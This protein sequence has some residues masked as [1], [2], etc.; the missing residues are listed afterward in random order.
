MNFGEVIAHTRKQ[1]GVSQKD[2]AA[3]I[4]KEDG[5]SISAQYLNDIERDRRNPP[6]DYIVQQLAA[7]LELSYEYLSYLAGQY[8]TDL[9]DVST[10]PERIEQAFQAFRRTLKGNSP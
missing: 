1:K 3:E 8:P 4:K 10:S 6:S 5:T 9:R 2:L 7:K